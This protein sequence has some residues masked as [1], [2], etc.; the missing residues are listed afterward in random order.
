APGSAAPVESVMVPKIKPVVPLASANWLANDTNNKTRPMSRPEFISKSPL[1]KS[2]KRTPSSAQ[3]WHTNIRFNGVVF[4]ENNYSPGCTL[5][6][7]GNRAK[8]A[9]RHT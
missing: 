2:F 8:A 4:C 1:R 3:Q 6:Q 7:E 9:K 5:C